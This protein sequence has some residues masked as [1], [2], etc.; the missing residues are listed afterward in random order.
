MRLLGFQPITSVTKRFRVTG[1]QL[2]LS[3]VTLPLFFGA[4]ADISGS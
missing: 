2:A 1:L 3:Q 4:R